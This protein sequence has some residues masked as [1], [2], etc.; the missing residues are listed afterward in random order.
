MNHQSQM[1]NLKQRMRQSL[2]KP[3]GLADLTPAQQQARAQAVADRLANPPPAPFFSPGL[4][5]PQ[6]PSSSRLEDKVARFKAQ[7]SKLEG[8]VYHLDQLK[9]LPEAL[10]QCLA[11]WQQSD[12]SGLTQRYFSLGNSLTKLGFSE[13]LWREITALSDEVLDEGAAAKAK[14]LREA[15]EHSLLTSAAYGLADT[16]SLVIES[17]AD[18]PILDHYYCR[19]SLVVLQQQ[20]L[21]TNLEALWPLLR[22]RFPTSTAW[23]RNLNLVTGPSRT[24]DVGQTIEL[25]AHGPIK[26]AV[27]IVP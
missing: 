3:L 2:A 6:S 26:L 5:H 8:E 20:Q 27:F 10:R 1:D 24:G 14:S 18:Q 13:E 12:K 21:L 11:N 9:L 25:G 23:P 19:N 16:G 22:Q 7:L 15:G 17:G 4:I